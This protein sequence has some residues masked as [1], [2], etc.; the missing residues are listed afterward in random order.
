MK[1]LKLFEEFNLLKLKELIDLGDIKSAKDMVD[2]E[3]NTMDIKSKVKDYKKKQYKKLSF[4]KNELFPYLHSKKDDRKIGDF[5]KELEKVSD[6]IQKTF[7]L[8]VEHTKDLKDIIKKINS[9]Y[10][11]IEHL[12]AQIGYSELDK[13]HE[14]DKFSMGWDDSQKR[15]VIETEKRYSDKS[16]NLFTK[17][18]NLEQLD[19]K[20]IIILKM[21]ILIISI[22]IRTI[23]YITH[24][25][26]YI[27]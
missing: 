11:N 22:N 21:Q 25:I 13:K 6:Y 26:Y 27:I 15:K 1:H 24:H 5:D 16:N 4:I 23:R 10:D 12:E 18:K 3:I 20:K 19:K 9:Y 7:E 17:L 14:F 8:D 2:T